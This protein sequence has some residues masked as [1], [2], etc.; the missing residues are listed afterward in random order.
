MRS[1]VTA[2]AALVLAACSPSPPMS[3][4]GGVDVT[5]CSIGG[6]VACQT[7]GTMTCGGSCVTV[8]PEGGGVPTCVGATDT[9]TWDPRVRCIRDG[10]DTRVTPVCAVR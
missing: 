9:S 10:V 4:A 8:C 7:D 5:I 6:G 1:I 3:D 2:A